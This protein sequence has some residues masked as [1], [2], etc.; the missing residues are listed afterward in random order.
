MGERS[1]KFDLVTL[2]GDSDHLPSLATLQSG[3]RLE[4]V[5]L[6]V[7]QTNLGE[8]GSC[9]YI[10]GEGPYVGLLMVR[11]LSLLLYT[12]PNFAKVRLFEALLCSV[13]SCVCRQQ[14]AQSAGY[15][16]GE[17]RAA[18]PQHLPI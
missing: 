13:Y 5:C 12:T 9:T 2:Q 6:I 10:H 8:V 15:P 1:G 11:A 14:G 7:L 4:L 16:D 17:A 18:Q 3:D